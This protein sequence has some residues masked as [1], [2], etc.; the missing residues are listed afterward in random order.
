MPPLNRPA[1]FS[2]KPKHVISASD[3]ANLSKRVVSESA[4]L[5]PGAAAL[6][7][8]FGSEADG[9]ALPCHA[10]KEDG[11]MRVMPSTVADL[12]EGKYA[13]LIDRF[14]IVDC[15]FPWEFE[16]GHIRGAINLYVQEQVESFFLVPGNGLRSDIPHLPL[17]SKSGD[18]HPE[19]KTVIIFHCEHS[20]M[21]APSQC[22][23]SAV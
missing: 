15:R 13:S 22:A 8:Q 3:S 18:A 23:C 4:A 1:T 16:G 14:V 12:V 7:E 9:K 17:P 6:P 11:L 21:R 10:V 19:G 20:E 2:F 5:N